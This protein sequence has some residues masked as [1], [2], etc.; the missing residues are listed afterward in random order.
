MGPTFPE[1]LSRP[2]IQAQISFNIMTML[3]HAQRNEIS[4]SEH[5]DL[6]CQLVHFA[7]HNDLYTKRCPDFWYCCQQRSSSD[8]C[9]MPTDRVHFR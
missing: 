6:Y 9:A 7:C 4:L 1:D 5:E 2:Q 8:I 3:D